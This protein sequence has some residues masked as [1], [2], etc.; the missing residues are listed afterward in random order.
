MR[1]MLVRIT[2]IFIAFTFTDIEVQVGYEGNSR[3]IDVS[4]G[5]RL[6]FNYKTRIYSYYIRIIITEEAG[7]KRFRL[8]LLV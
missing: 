5:L 3:V 1:R 4:K 2:C 8:C 6:V 7:C